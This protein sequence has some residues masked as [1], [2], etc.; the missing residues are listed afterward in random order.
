MMTL[1]ANLG[2]AKKL[3]LGGLGPACLLLV[4]LFRHGEL[5]LKVD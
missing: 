3:D 5:V 2:P 4:A 1:R